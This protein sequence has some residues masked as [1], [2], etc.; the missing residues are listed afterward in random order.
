MSE[1]AGLSWGESR[2][3]S[4]AGLSSSVAWGEPSHPLPLAEEVN[5]T[6]DCDRCWSPL[7]LRHL[8]SLPSPELDDLGGCCPPRPPGAKSFL[9]AM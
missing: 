6:C 3:G 4:G 2:V 5:D 1:G 7:G 9:L 8:G